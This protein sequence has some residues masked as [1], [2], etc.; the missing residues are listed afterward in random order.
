MSEVNLKGIIDLPEDIL[1]DFKHWVLVDGMKPSTALRK[2]MEKYDC[3]HPDPALP[4]YL[5]RYTWDDLDL[6]RTGLRFQILDSGYPNCDPSQ[7]S[8]DDFDAGLTH[9]LSLPPGW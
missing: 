3:P 7:F 2:I 4:I 9:L 8:D 6:G 5:A 1:P